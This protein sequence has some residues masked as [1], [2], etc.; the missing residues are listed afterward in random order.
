[1][2]ATTFGNPIETLYSP[3]MAKTEMLGVEDTRKAFS[4]RIIA[5]D[6]DEIHTVVTLHGQPAAVLVDVS[7][8]ARAREALGEP[9]D[10]RRGPK[11][12]KKPEAE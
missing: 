12:L 11:P 7:W 9:T 2:T 4:A 10:I 6:S 1:M 3:D 5:A 8:Y